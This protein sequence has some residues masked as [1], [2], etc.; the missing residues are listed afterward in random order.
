VKTTLASGLTALVESSHASP[1]VAFQV[2]IRSGGADEE[3]GERGLAHLH[4]HMLFK[5]TPTR[6]VGEIASSIEACGGQINAW[7]SNDHT[8]YHIVLPAHEWRQGL[9][10]LADAVCHSLFDP[11]ELAREIEVVVEEI[12]RAAD[13]PSQVGYQ[14]LFEQIFAG[15]PYSLPVLGT[16]DSVRGMTSER[17]RTF[18]HRHYRAANTTVVA[19]GD[20]PEQGVLEAIAEAFADLPHGPPPARNALPAPRPPAGAIVPQ[21][22]FSES[23]VLLAWPA[24]HLDHADVPALD[25]LAMVLGQ[26]DSSRLVRVLQRE[27]ELVNDVGASTYTP[28]R[29]GMTAI[30]LLTNAERLR[31]AVTAALELLRDVQAQGV[32]QTELDKARNNVLA[33]ATYKLETVQGLAHSLG[34]YDAA[35]GDPD[36]ERVY[37]QRIAAVTVGDLTRVARDWLRADQLQIVAMPGQDAAG[38]LPEPA[39]LLAEAQAALRPLRRATQRLRSGDVVDGIERIVLPSGDVLLVQ[40]DATVPMLGLRVAALGGLRSETRRLSGSSHLLGKM[41]TRGTARRSGD[42]IAQRIESLAAGLSG[43]SGRNSLGLQA[44]TLSASQSEVLDLFF[45]ALFHCALPETELEQ[46][47]HVQLED[48]RHQAD[49]PARQVMRALAAALYGEHPY[50]L[51]PL[52]TTESLEGIAREDL[53]TMLRG[54]LAPGRLCYAASGDV[55][56]EALADAIAAQTPTDRTP[57]TVPERLPTPVLAGVTQVRLAADKQQAHLALGFRGTTLHKPE[58]YALDVLSTLLS[59]QSG[60]LFLELRDR[61][62]L[63]YT[64]SAM[65]VEGI[66]EGYFAV[67]MGTSP[68]KLDQALSG[69]HGELDKIVQAPVPQVQLDRTKRYLAGGH[70]IGLQR[71]SARASTLCLD[72]LY[73]LGR[74]A[75]RGHLEAL[76][77]VSA[78]DV[79]RAAR[80][81]LDLTRCVEV[82]L[83]P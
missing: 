4:E 45:D 31:A 53:L 33:E 81:T 56:P 47:R 11:E 66:D 77:A 50:G 19:A 41:L 60:R 37:N 5:G 62:S 13:S 22:T 39:D 25:L 46:E 2:W 36:W 35:T 3:D 44:V 7:T 30:T 65:H 78:E 21:T 52:G 18:Y 48:I 79:L 54:Q 23:R 17:M 1:V 63:A 80:A 42:E 20:L 27:R 73:G 6:G 61:Q 43:Q 51:D 58:R 9:D 49:A 34:Y 64:V 74:Q 59:G 26:G 32:T 38:A 67:Y 16:A 70:A 8:C 55:D 83:A 14:R 24:P 82:V 28:V 12:K 15:H 69:L 40:P 29:A 72:E 71:R 10:V 57:Q 68:D 76:L 75:Y